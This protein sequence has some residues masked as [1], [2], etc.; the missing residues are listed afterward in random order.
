[1]SENPSLWIIK[2][3]CKK[4]QSI[5][6]II[7]KNGKFGKAKEYLKRNP[8]C[9]IKISFKVMENGTKQIKQEIKTSSFLLQDNI[10]FLNNEDIT[11]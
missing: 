7:V 5:N 3:T 11:M 9:E 10:I 4:I 2:F 1:M 6:L 8:K